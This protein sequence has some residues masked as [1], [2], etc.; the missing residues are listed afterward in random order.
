[1]GKPALALKLH[2]KLYRLFK[3]LFLETNP[4]PVKAALALMGLASEEIRLPLVA[5]S[6][7]NRE[8]IRAS[9][10]ACGVLK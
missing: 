10:T 4:A 2:Y 9:L 7:A 8:I 5:I 1:M 3:D 6:P